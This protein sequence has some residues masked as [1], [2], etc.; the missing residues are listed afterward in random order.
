MIDELVNAYQ[1][2]CELQMDSHSIPQSIAAIHRIGLL[3]SSGFP[4]DMNSYQELNNR[5]DT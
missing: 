2:Y 3:Y 1:E 4:A 5:I